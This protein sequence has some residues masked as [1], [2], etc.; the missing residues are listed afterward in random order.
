MHISKKLG[1]GGLGLRALGWGAAN[2]RTT[3]NF[4]MFT[5]HSTGE[6]QLVWEVGVWGQAVPGVN[7]QGE[8]AAVALHGFAHVVNYSKHWNLLAHAV[9]VHT[10]TRRLHYAEPDLYSRGFATPMGLGPWSLAWPCPDQWHTLTQDSTWSLHIPSGLPQ[11]STGKWHL[12]VLVQM[13]IAA[14]ICH[15][16]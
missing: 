8:E 15:H 7:I 4:S 11:L 5:A 13:L 6:G 10:Q 2:Y 1:P 16:F 14:E 12:E 3:W 9:S